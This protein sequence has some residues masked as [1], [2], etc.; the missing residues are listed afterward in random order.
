MLSAARVSRLHFSLLRRDTQVAVSC[1]LSAMSHATLAMVLTT[2]SAHHAVLTS[3][4]HSQMERV[5]SAL[6]TVLSF[7]PFLNLSQAIVLQ[8][9]SLFLPPSACL[10]KERAYRFFFLSLSSS[11]SQVS[12]QFTISSWCLTLR[13]LSEWTELSWL[14]LSC[15]KCSQHCGLFLPNLSWVLSLNWL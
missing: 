5:D 10:R 7:T 8:S 6:T 12:Y 1:L 13:S 14:R 9:L 15:P 11:L 4:R 2:T 3:S